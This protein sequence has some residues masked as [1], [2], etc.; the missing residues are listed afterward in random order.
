MDAGTEGDPRVFMLTVVLLLLGSNVSVASSPSPVYPTQSVGDQGADT[1]ML[2]HLLA[3][4]GYAVPVTGRFDAATVQAVEAFEAST[5][6]PKDGIVDQQAWDRLVVPLREGDEGP[7]VRGFES[8]L[9]RKHDARFR[10]DDR[11]EADTKQAV[12][13]FQA[14]MGLPPTGRVDGSTWE[15]LTWHYVYPR[16]DGR[17]LCAYWD[18][19]DGWGTASTV[20]RIEAA[21]DRFKQRGLGGVAVGDVSL[22]HGGPLANHSSHREGM[23]VDLRLVRD[24][25]AQC[26]LGCTIG[27][28]CYDR[29]AT[30]LLIDDLIDASHGHLRFVLVADPWLEG[31]RDVVRF[32]AAHDDHL[33][34]RYCEAKHTNPRFAGCLGTTP[35]PL[36]DLPQPSELPS[37]AGSPAGV[38]V[39]EGSVDGI[40]GTVTRP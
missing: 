17:M 31:Y 35:D 12:A 29:E 6:L 2:Q 27:Q 26:G 19:D 15:A 33:H 4:H 32:D 11:F 7:A 8:S 9:D 10:V 24:D 34:V 38:G 3:E 21:V 30:R 16:Y 25:A 22:E 40:E 13:S 37:P 20:A 23:D 18:T 39:P 1:R 14:H 28:P 36:L 5:G